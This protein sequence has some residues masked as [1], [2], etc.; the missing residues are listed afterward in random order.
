M[1]KRR[2]RWLPCAAALP[3][4]PG[5]LCM[6]GPG[7]HAK[8]LPGRWRTRGSSA[9]REGPGTCCRSAARRSP[10]SRRRRAA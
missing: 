2:L 4:S 5:A 7:T 1:R 8:A 10:R 6:G 9:A 3:A